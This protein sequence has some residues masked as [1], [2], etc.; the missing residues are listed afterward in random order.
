MTTAT[1]TEPK[2]QTI[3]DH[4]REVLADDPK[5]A[6]EAAIAET[7]KLKIALVREQSDT[8]L[9]SEITFG[10]D[11]ME[12]VS[13]AALWRVANLYS[14]SSM[15]PEHYQ[16]QPEN[17]LIAAQMA[18]RCKVDIFMFMQ[19]S[20]IVHGKPGIEA[21]LAIAMLNASGKIKGRVRYDFTGEGKERQCTASVIDRETSEEIRMPLHWSTVV[22]EGWDKPKKG[23]PSKWI[24]LTDQMFRYRSAVFLIRAHYPEVMMGMQTSEELEDVGPPKVAVTPSSAETGDDGRS[25]TDQIADQLEPPAPAKSAD[26][27]APVKG[28][29]APTD[30]PDAAPPSPEQIATELLGTLKRA[31]SRVGVLKVQQELVETT[32]ILGS[33]LADDVQAEISFRLKEFDDQPAE[34]DAGKTDAKQGTLV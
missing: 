25:A 21:K 4:A 1:S 33:K 29:K 30:T 11:G 34:S 23:N 26:S 9:M 28:D 14:R 22:A 13:L 24:T 32:R 3:A 2:P 12:A 6:L 31:R 17:C 7:E 8:K 16:K 20:Y 10:P 27:D 15:V 5:L 18:Q 19:N